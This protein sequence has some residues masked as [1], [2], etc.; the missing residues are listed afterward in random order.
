[1]PNASY[2]RPVIGVLPAW[3]I[4]PDEMP[5]H[6]C[7]QI[8]HGILA[9][10]HAS[11]CDLL[12]AVGTGRLAWPTVAPDSD[13]VPIGPWNTDGLIVFTPLKD[14]KRSAYIQKV[15]AEGH[16]VFYIATGE[17]GPS[18]QA[19]NET[20]I[21]EAVRHLV[22]HG[23][24]RI[25][26]IAGDQQDSGDTVKRLVAYRTALEECGL[27]YDP[28]LM[29]YGG[30][31]FD[32]GYQALQQILN[33]GEPFSAVQASNDAS[34]IGAL[35]ALREAGIQVPEQVALIG[36]DDQP[37]AA[38]QVPSLTSVHTPLMEIGA[39][40]VEQMVA[41]IVDGKPLESIIL[42]TCI[43]YRQSCG[44]L[45]DTML[46]V[47]QPAA[48]LEPVEPRQPLEQAGIAA[49]LNRA[50]LR[51]TANPS[52]HE[53]TQS[54]RRIASALLES[55]QHGET[56][57]FD[58]AVLSFLHGIE[59]RRGDFGSFQDA[60][61]ALRLEVLYLLQI[62]PEIGSP[63]FIEDLFQRARVAICDSLQWANLR[64]YYDLE[65]YSYKLSMLTARLSGCLDTRQLVKIL[66]E[67]VEKIGIRHARLILFDPMDGDP[68][69]GS[70]WV[71]PDAEAD[72]AM[73]R[74]LTRQFPPPQLYP[75][76][77][78]LSLAVL[79]LAF[80]NEPFGYIAFDSSKN[81][82][83]PPIARQIS[84]N[85]KAAQLHEKVVD[86][87][88][89]DELTGVFNRRYLDLFLRKEIARHQRFRHKLSIIMIDIDDFKIYNDTYGHQ[90]GDEALKIVGQS[91]QSHLRETDFV[92][93]YGGDEFILVLAETD[94]DGAFSATAHVQASMTAQANLFHPITLS[95]GIAT[96]TNGEVSLNQLIALADEAL[97]DA[98]LGGKNR[99]C[100]AKSQKP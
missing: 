24:R 37:D 76:E 77:E 30:H 52:A 49:R 98:K 84:A 19:D 63:G 45:P 2:H 70:R 36:F 46:R 12:L 33:S 86:L 79:P 67:D 16:P 73:E 87:S 22:G 66:E 53:L 100:A 43:T 20:G 40:A 72:P 62:W 21:R 47:S 82:S 83:L 96:M 91:L 44:C 78:N 89:N 17:V 14:E 57:Y 61:S 25:A 93:R 56:A 99:V 4:Y 74:F 54:Y 27:A 26:F 13:F 75:P 8:L 64:A 95:M 92:A 10:A 81:A 7:E 60:L 3:A 39:K 9:Q 6:Y 35:I 51:S 48:G 59:Q 15:Q 5:D 88:L 55:I 97:Y 23:H 50:M 32:G 94:M 28:H 42:P 41:R 31:V 38:A 11:G 65:N 90:A 34:A 18:I 80:Q 85:L 71:C 58:Q 1:M 69:A 68:V 29:A